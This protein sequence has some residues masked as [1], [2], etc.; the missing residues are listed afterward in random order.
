MSRA[1]I[2][3]AGQRF[4][5][6]TAIAR[7]GEKCF[8]AY[9]WVFQCDCGNK[10][11]RRPGSVSS[12]IRNGRVPMCDQCRSRNEYEVEGGVAC[13]DVSTKTHPEAKTLVD[14]CDLDLA[15]ATG[16]RWHAA[17]GPN[18]LL[19]V[20]QKNGGYLHRLIMGD[21]EGFEIDHINGNGLDN[22]RDNLRIVT[23]AVNR[24]N[25]RISLRNK[26]G[27]VGV[28]SKQGKYH[29]YIVS[30]AGDQEYLGSFSNLLDAAAARKSAERR[31]GYHEN[32]GRRA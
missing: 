16:G 17:R 19:Y 18:G 25:T 8:T 7:S 27:V 3:I 5:K 24:R 22:R 13:I 9:K 28:F 1:G 23:S 20:S 14:V 12:S 10:V 6:L 11:I 30:L 4:G 26:S 32:H 21:P 2:D 29:A 15:I 31:Y